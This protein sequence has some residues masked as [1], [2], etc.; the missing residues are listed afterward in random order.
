MLQQHD[1]D[2]PCG[3]PLQSFNDQITTLAQ[4]KERERKSITILGKE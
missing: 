1:D 2:Y 3:E 4:D